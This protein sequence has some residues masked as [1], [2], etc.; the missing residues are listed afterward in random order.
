MGPCSSTPLTP[1]NTAGTHPADGHL[2]GGEGAGLVGADDGGAAQGLHRGQAAHDGIFL[3]H[4]ARAQRQ[5]RGDDGREA[6]GDGGHRQGH[7]GLEVVD[8]PSK[9][10]ATVDGV[11]EVADVDDPDGDAH[12]ENHF[13]ELLAE[14]IQL[15]LQGGLLGFCLHHLVS[16]LPDLRV[17]PCCNDDPHG[18]P[19][20]NVGALEGM[21]GNGVN[22]WA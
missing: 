9:P 10:G 16:D 12:Q 4:A 8:G 7:R 11:A 18:L 6:L 14:L 1:Q 5:A 17:H 3:G 15:L 2:V 21:E 19:S 13:G 22:T 20:G